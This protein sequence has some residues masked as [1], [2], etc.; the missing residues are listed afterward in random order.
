MEKV[1]KGKPV[2]DAITEDL[3]IRTEKLKAREVK[4]ILKSLFRIKNTSK[5]EENDE[6]KIH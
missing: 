2:A 1:L 6:N 5:K 3:R 4:K